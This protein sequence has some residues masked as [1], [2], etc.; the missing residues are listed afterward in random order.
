MED[1]VAVQAMLL[2][3]AIECALKGKYVKDGGRLTDAKGRFVG[4]PG[5]G[6]HDLVQLADAAKCNLS[7]DERT[8]FRRLNTFVEWA[9]R[10]PVPLNW[11]K[12]LS[13]TVGA[14]GPL[15]PRFILRQEI[16]IA[17]SVFGRLE[18]EIAPPLPEAQ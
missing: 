12:M 6:D 16:A 7:D 13:T 15:D 4:V 1:I 5:A 8:A 17:E 18:N 9:G 2:G 3:L 11:E 10:Y 14:R